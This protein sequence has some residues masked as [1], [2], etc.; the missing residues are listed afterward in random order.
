MTNAATNLVESPMAG[1][2]QASLR[3]RSRG[4]AQIERV[5]PQVTTSFLSVSL[6]RGQILQNKSVA[7]S[8][9]CVLP[10]CTS[11]FLLLEVKC[12]CWRWD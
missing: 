2:A 9:T 8:T 4:P 7:R 10:I 11:L 12:S 6:T 3:Q 1:E 5:P